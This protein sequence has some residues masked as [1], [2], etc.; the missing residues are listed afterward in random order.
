M[1]K[2][3]EAYHQIDGD[4][5]GVTKRLM[6]EELVGRFAKSFLKMKALPSSKMRFRRET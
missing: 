1:S 3:E 4:W 5:E 2:L 6:G